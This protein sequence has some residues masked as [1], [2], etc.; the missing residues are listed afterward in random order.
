MPDVNGLELYGLA[1]GLG[2]VAGALLAVAQWR[3]LRRFVQMA[4]RWIVA[5]ACAWTLGMVLVFIGTSFIPTSGVTPGVALI[6]LTFVI[7]AGAVVG[8]HP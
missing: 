7:A 5:N 1:A 2:F 8:R 4:S 6:L 3:V